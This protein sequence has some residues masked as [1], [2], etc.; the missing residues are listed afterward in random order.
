M[1][2][3]EL[4]LKNSWMHGSNMRDHAQAKII[5]ICPLIT[6]VK[7]DFERREHIWSRISISSK[8]SQNTNGQIKAQIEESLM[9]ILKC[10]PFS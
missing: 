8:G 6:L 7:V 1:T 9:V 5:M 10:I 2:L 3:R 4:C